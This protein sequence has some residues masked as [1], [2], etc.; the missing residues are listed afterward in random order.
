VVELK[1]ED[2]HVI[3]EFSDV[4]PDDLH[5]MAPEWAIE[6]QSGTAPIA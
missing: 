3:R 4:F 5:G 6:L 1:L 2:I